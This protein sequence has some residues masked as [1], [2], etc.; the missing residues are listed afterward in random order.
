[1]DRRLDLLAERLVD[2]LDPL[3]GERINHIIGAIALLVATALSI[4]ASLLHG[5]RL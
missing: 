3:Q 2:P 5:A 4:L 1:M